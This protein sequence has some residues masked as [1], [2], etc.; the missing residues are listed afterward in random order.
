MRLYSGTRRIP[1]PE[2]EHGYTSVKDN[3]KLTEEH[4]EGSKEVND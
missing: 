2:A 3:T 1:R 4:R